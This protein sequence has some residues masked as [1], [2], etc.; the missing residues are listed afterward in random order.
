MRFAALWSSYDDRGC[1][2]VEP[3]HAVDVLTA[4]TTRSAVALTSQRSSISQY[5]I[6]PLAKGLGMLIEG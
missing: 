2:S 6:R 1:K 5:L 4:P 3:L